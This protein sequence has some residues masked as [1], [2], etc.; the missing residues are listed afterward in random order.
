VQPPRRVPPTN[1][2]P[3]VELTNQEKGEVLERKHPRAQVLYE[4]IRL[5]GEHELNRPA[6]AL[7]WS[8]VAAGLSM[9]FSLM[10]MGLLR[11]ALPEAPWAKLIVNLG[12]SVGFLVVIVAR[13]QLFT[14]N[15]LTPVIP[16]LHNRNAQTLRRVVRLW[17]IVLVAN[18]LGTL[19]FAGGMHSTALFP[20][21]VRAAFAAIGRSAFEGG[22]AN[23]FL[24]AIV[25]GW[26]IAILVWMLAGA[27]A[28]GF[29]VVVI[30]YL[31]GLGELSHV[32]AGST[33][34]LFAVFNGDASMWD[35][36]YRFLLPV[37][38][39]NMLGGIAL[40]AALSYAQVAADEAG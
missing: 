1:A 18:L 16:L 7:A 11:A 35:Y 17:S 13:Q 3:G 36:L 14:E 15:T 34:T 38:L 26:L 32:I 23:H 8:G 30:T 33:E 9:G 24:R 19:A 2:E 40:V 27:Q 12:Y 10:A 6:W 39:G 31:I 4:T 25:S 5:E 21:E 20:E 22:F 37:G 28:R 29:L